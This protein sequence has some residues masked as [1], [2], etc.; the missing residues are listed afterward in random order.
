MTKPVVDMST[1]SGE[2]Q[3]TVG[4][5][6]GDAVGTDVGTGVGASV[7]TGVAFGSPPLAPAL[8]RVTLMK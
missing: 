7:G 1:V 8:P 4:T 6:V 2:K 5:A 3:G